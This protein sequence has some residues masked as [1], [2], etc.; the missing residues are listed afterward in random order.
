MR[1]SKGT[2]ARPTSRGHDGGRQSAS[3]KAGRAKA[4]PRGPNVRQQSPLWDWAQAMLADMPVAESSDS[5]PATAPAE[6]PLPALKL[7]T[8]CQ[9]DRPSS[10]ASTRSGTASTLQSAR[11]AAAG[12]TNGGLRG[13][14]AELELDVED[15]VQGKHQ[16]E[17]D[18]P[19]RKATIAWGLESVEMLEGPVSEAAAADPIGCDGVDFS[20]PTLCPASLP[21]RAKKEPEA[22]TEK[23]VAAKPGSRS[24]RKGTASRTVQRPSSTPL[25]RQSAHFMET[26]RPGSVTASLRNESRCGLKVA[27]LKAVHGT[28]APSGTKVR[29]AN[30]RAHRLL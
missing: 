28:T 10:I 9:P 5:R 12:V 7:K 22:G 25:R 3:W 11:S 24:S 26:H 23:K 19:V 13:A 27:Q 20:G 30:E 15:S 17:L 4:T 29:R 21:R 18:T 16:H 6:G 14:P 1:T 2:T 8:N